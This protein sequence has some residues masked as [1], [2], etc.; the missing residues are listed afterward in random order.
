[1]YEALLGHYLGD[2][3]CVTLFYQHSPLKCRPNRFHGWAC[4]VGYT[5]TTGKKPCTNTKAYAHRWKAKT[6]IYEALLGHYLGDEGC[7][8]L[9]YQHEAHV[10]P[11]EYASYMPMA[12]RLLIVLR[13][14]MS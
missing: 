10:S 11:G 7:V 12:M 3:G 5:R 14:L 13:V 4:H 2:V 8:A 1:M 6:R 9:L